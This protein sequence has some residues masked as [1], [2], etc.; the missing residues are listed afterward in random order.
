MK[1]TSENLPGREDAPEGANPLL[2]E[3]VRSL[4]PTHAENRGFLRGV[5]CIFI[6]F[7]LI[8]ILGWALPLNV[9][10]LPQIKH[11]VRPYLL[12]TGLF[13]SWDFFAPNPRPIN[14]YIQAVAITQNHHMRVFNFPRMEQLGYGKRYREERYRKFAEVLCDQR[15]AALWPDVARHVARLLNNSTDPPQM[16]ILMKFQ[17]PIKYGV[18][19]AEEPVSKPEFFY[20]YYVSREDLR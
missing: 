6:L 15:Y 11:I 1:A 9:V 18:T 2:S 20:E 4:Q 13:Q 14:S 5:I 19:P 17:A 10:P 12:W 8:A 7:N 16:V 3:P